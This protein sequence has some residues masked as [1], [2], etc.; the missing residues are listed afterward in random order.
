MHLTIVV[1]N[2]HSCTFCYHSERTSYQ[3]FAPVMLAIFP[4]ESDEREWRYFA[5]C[6]MKIVD[7]TILENYTWVNIHYYSQWYISFTTNVNN[8]F[9]NYCFYFHQDWLTN[10]KRKLTNLAQTV[11]IQFT[12]FLSL[13]QVLSCY[14]ANYTLWE[15]WLKKWTNTDNVY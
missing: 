7:S 2:F 15:G 11:S 10:L 8:S 1:V 5:S 4:N 12:L 6:I 14:S 9:Y 13:I 3:F